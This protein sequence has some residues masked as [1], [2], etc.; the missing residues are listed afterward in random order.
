MTIPSSGTISMLDIVKEFGPSSNTSIISDLTNLGGGDWSWFSGGGQVGD[1]LFVDDFTLNDLN[2][3]IVTASTVGQFGPGGTVTVRWY[4]AVNPYLGMLLRVTTPI[5]GKSQPFSAG[6]AEGLANQYRITAT[7]SYANYYTDVFQSFIGYTVRVPDGRTGTILDTNRT[8]SGSPGAVTS[9]SHLISLTGGAPGAGSYFVAVPQSVLSLSAYY[10]GGDYVPTG[11]VGF[12]NGVSTVIP[13]SSTISLANFYGANRQIVLR[14][15]QSS[16]G[17]STLTIPAG[18]WYVYAQA[19]GAGGGGGAGDAGIFGTR[20]GSGGSFKAKFVINASQ[21][22]RLAMSTGWGGGPGVGQARDG[23]GGGAG[24]SYSWTNNTDINSIDNTGNPNFRSTY[25]Y[26]GPN[27]WN[28]FLEDEAIW[29]SLFDEQGLDARVPVSVLFPLSGNYVFYG[30]ADNDFYAYIDTTSELIGNFSGYTT[31]KNT[32]RYVTAG[33]HT[34]YFAAQN[35]GGPRGIAFSIVIQTGGAQVFNS[36]GIT[37]GG[38]TSGNFWFLNGG[39]GGHAGRYGNSGA[40]GGGGSGTGLLWYPNND[41]LT[42][43]PTVL[44]IAPGGGGGAGTGR[45][46]NPGANGGIYLANWDNRGTE[47]GSGELLVYNP[48]PGTIFSAAAGGGNSA[49]WTGR[50][51]GN[52]VPYALRGSLKGQGGHNSSAFYPPSTNYGWS[53]ESGGW[54]GGAGG[55]GGAPW[56]YAGGYADKGDSYWYELTTSD[57]DGNSTTQWISPNESSGAGGN[58]GFCFLNITNVS[59][60]LTSQTNTYLPEQ[61]AGGLGGYGVGSSGQNGAIAVRVSNVDDGIYPIA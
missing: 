39:E 42:G 4:G 10:S 1:I 41:P 33:W 11:T 36:R 15:G 43:R 23:G 59:S 18:I 37:D 46:I 22:G 16:S 29:S 34:I 7:G 60:Y 38:Y 20:G 57:K 56:G 21:T 8:I 54:D 9:Y 30:A 3:G 28:Y 32:V 55:G 51:Q 45:Y 12:P 49:W 61:G 47:L 52:R 48:N 53:S 14:G 58:Q 44:G 50:G 6:V 27:T 40:G 17:L 25:C 19:V 5:P 35:Y 26:E 2:W 31:I 24:R 13:R